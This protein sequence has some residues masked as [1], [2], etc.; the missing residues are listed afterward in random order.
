MM[1]I[2]GVYFAR[3]GFRGLCLRP[4]IDEGVLSR[5]MGVGAGIRALWVIVCWQRCLGGLGV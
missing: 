3:I 5:F 4:E 2:R 1:S